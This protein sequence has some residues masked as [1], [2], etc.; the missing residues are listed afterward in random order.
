MSAI[1]DDPTYIS[2][3]LLDRRVVDA[4]GE[5][6]GR[7]DDLAF[8]QHGL[9]S[10]RLVGILMGPEALGA[11]LGGVLGDIVAAAGRLRPDGP[12]RPEVAIADLASV[13]IELRLK[14]NRDD[15][16]FPRSEGW[17]REHVIGRIP[18]ARHASSS[19][20]MPGGSSSG[21][22]ASRH[23]SPNTDPSHGSDTPVR[24]VLAST[25][26]GTRVVDRDG[27]E[28][29][30]LHDLRLRTERNEHRVEGLVTGP[31]V[32]AERF[33]YTY[34]EVSGPWL[35][36]VLM[37]HLAKRTRYIPWNDIVETTAEQIVA[38]N[39][40]DAYGSVADVR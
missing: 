29:G 21:R 10:P 13:G 25:L 30:R 26:L 15:L 39:T 36:V 31:G 34:G 33:G 8:E 28:I 5:P 4:N 18:G 7:V 40:R 37:R 17:V 11:R 20:E 2:L 3:R 24:R 14:A 27:H 19:G 38:R 12:N 6:L 23:A 22:G 32:I 1:S 35:L 16:P 9:G